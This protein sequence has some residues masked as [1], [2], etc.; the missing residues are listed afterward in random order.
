VSYGH[1]KSAEH[2]LYHAWLSLEEYQA[3]LLEEEVTDLDDFQSF[4][5]ALFSVYHLVNCCHMSQLFIFS[6]G[7]LFDQIRI[8]YSAH[9]L[10]VMRIR[11]DYLTQP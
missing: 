5:H 9:C 6:L 1:L 10:E 8:N 4:M 11:S 7:A 3:S 2:A